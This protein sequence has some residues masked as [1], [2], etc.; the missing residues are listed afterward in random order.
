M[1]KKQEEQM[2]ILVD[3]QDKRLEL[4]RGNAGEARV[5]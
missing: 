2:P 1:L 3:E 4:E 5:D